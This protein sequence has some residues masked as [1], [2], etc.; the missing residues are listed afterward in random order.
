[1]EWAWSGGDM[2]FAGMDTIATGTP[3]KTCCLVGLLKQGLWSLHGGDMLQRFGE[4][5][6]RVLIMCPSHPNVQEQGGAG[7]AA[8]P[9]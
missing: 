9:A 2:S 1:M 3:M 4:L 6:F 5:D 7:D 8:P